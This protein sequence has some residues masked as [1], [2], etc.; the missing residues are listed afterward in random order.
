MGSALAY[1]AADF[2]GGLA[3]RRAPVLAVTV[4]SQGVG[5]LVLLPALLVLGGE[6]SAVALLVGAAAGLVGTAGLVLYLVALATGPMGVA[7]PLAAVVGA[8]LPVVAGLLLGER[9]SV[10][11]LVGVPLGLLAVGLTCWTRKPPGGGVGPAR[12]PALLALAGGAGF[13]LFF[14]LLSVTPPASGLWPLVG[15]RIS[16]VAVLVA[17]LALRRGRSSLRGARALAAGMGALDMTANILF[18]AAVRLGMLSLTGLLASLYPV[19]VIVLARL[20]LRE[21]LTAQQRVG[22][23]AA[24]VAVALIGG[25]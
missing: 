1:G 17:V 12:R 5:L 13:G 9:P 20:L 23:L 16:S 25:G 14:V 24:L 18:L 21:R 7:A 19:V 2:T 10:P 3:A 4:L 15:A 8:V 22:A 6:Y 11:A